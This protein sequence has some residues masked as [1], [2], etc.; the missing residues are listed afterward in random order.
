M[1]KCF[2]TLVFLVLGVHIT[3]VDKGLVLDVVKVVG[4][5]LGVVGVVAAVTQLVL[6][7]GLPVPGEIR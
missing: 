6:S 2:T 3:T 5:R 4:L 1:G 7:K